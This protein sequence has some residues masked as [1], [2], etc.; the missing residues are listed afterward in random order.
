MVKRLS[1][2]Y[3]GQ[4]HLAIDLSHCLIGRDQHEH[5][6]FYVRGSD[7]SHFKLGEPLHTDCASISELDTTHI[8]CFEEVHPF[9]RGRRFKRSVLY[10]R[11]TV[12]VNYNFNTRRKLFIGKLISWK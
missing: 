3:S 6:H 12:G 9:C 5:N 7:S 4:P 1:I 11:R 8:K 2:I 10:H